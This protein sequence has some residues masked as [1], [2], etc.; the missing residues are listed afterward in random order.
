MNSPLHARLFLDTEW[1]DSAAR[2]LVSLALV[3]GDGV[4]RFYAEVDPLPDAPTPFVRR[5]VYPLLERGAAAL[6]PTA[7]TR[8]LRTFLAGVA[9]AEIVYDYGADG[10]LLRQ[11][12]AG[13]WPVGAVEAAALIPCPAPQL[14]L[15][16]YGALRDAVE[17]YFVAR[18]DAAARRH[19]AAVDAEALRW[20]VVEKLEW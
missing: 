3:S 12:L 7:F 9:P 17:A 11:V 10:A 1:A 20:A 13:T 5:V 18:P 6:S 14:T 16:E 4:Q 8:A 15:M 2:E 19:H